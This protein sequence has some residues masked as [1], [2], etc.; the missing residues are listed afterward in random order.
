MRNLIGPVAALAA[1]LSL[2]LATPASAIPIITITDLT[3]GPPVVVLST[4]IDLVGS[5]VF[6]DETVSFSAILHIPF[7]QGV[8][9]L[10]GLPYNF[11]LT[12]LGGGVS[13]VATVLAPQSGGP[14]AVDWEQPF[15][16]SF[17]SS[18]QPI[19]W[20][21]GID[22]VQPELGTVQ[23]C[24]LVSQTFDNVLGLRIQSDV[25]PVPEPT[26]LALLGVGLVAL[27]A[28]RRRA[29]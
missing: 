5:M 20:T 24:V 13:D 22:C 25:D 19:Q 2:S 23:S 6:S 9:G 21:P 12:E 17:T 18:D 15:S 3:E 16:F 10:D 27:R 7:G 28:R 4:G 8:L 26:T 14:G 11:V 1:F 29:S